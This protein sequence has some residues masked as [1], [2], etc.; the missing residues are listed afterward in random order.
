MY[1]YHLISCL[2]IIQILFKYF[3]LDKSGFFF[4]FVYFFASILA[5]LKSWSV[6]GD[7]GAYYNIFNY[8]A[9]NPDYRLVSDSYSLEPLFFY[10]NYL[11][12]FISDDF[13]YLLILINLFN[14][15][16]IYRFIIVF[17]FDKYLTTLPLYIVFIYYNQN[18]FYV[19]Q[20][21]ALSLLALGLTFL[22]RRRVLSFFI[23][24]MAPFFHVPS[25]LFFICL[26]K[27]ESIFKSKLSLIILTI[28]LLIIYFLNDYI[29]IFIF[30]NLNL[31]LKNYGSYI[32][33]NMYPRRDILFD[34][35]PF[36]L[37]TSSY[38]VI[39]NSNIV[40]SIKN[41]PAGLILIRG[42]LLYGALPLLFTF[43]SDIA[44]RTQF[45]FV[46]SL[47]LF[48]FIYKIF[49]KGIYNYGYSLLVFG[50]VLSAFVVRFSNLHWILLMDP[51]IFFF[52][53][54]MV[55]NELEWDRRLSLVNLLNILN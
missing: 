31:P 30:N 8:I 39:I 16:A 18:F 40:N 44:R 47:F 17:N 26:L 55:C 29:L 41:I 22:V 6:G 3:L 15:L 51:Y 14:T 10:I 20:G 49:K 27:I 48:G 2:V 7:M 9:K 23:F 46:L 21:I 42:L 53:C 12:T 13:N 43:N 4:R 45:Y 38:Y 19:R 28:G 35:I 37:F 52:S 11:F 33:D 36:L 5:V 34:F 50:Y 54:D 1:F 24:L 25:I 32:S